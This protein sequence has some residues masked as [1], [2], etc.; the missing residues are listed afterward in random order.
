MTLLRTCIVAVMT[1]GMTVD[2]LAA[3][4]VLEDKMTTAVAIRSYL[5]VS[6]RETPKDTRYLRSDFI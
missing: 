5:F 1:E 4:R 3:I 2:P 6:T